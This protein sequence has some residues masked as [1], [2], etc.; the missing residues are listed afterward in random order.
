PNRPSTP[1]QPK[2]PVIPAEPAVAV[3]TP[4]AEERVEPVYVDPKDEKG[5]LPRTGSQ[6]SDQTGSGLLAAIASLTFFGLANRKKK[7]E[8]D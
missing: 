1:E 8:E 6:T 7:S 4:K 2:V 5:V 3:Q